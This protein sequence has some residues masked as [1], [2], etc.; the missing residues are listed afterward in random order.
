MKTRSHAAVKLLPM[1]LAVTFASLLL[2]SRTQSTQAQ[3]ARDKMTWEYANDSAAL[4]NDF[5]RAGYFIRR[6]N[7]SPNW[8]IFL[9]SGGLC[10]SRDSCNRRFFVREVRSSYLNHKY[11]L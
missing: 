10:Y 2:F 9:E 5:T 11:L 6:N 1:A 7:E 4:C 3:A 8:L